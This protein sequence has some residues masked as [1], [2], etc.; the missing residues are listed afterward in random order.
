MERSWP[1]LRSSPSVV[2]RQKETKNFSQ[3]KRSAGWT[4]NWDHPNTK[5][6]HIRWINLKPRRLVILV[7]NLRV[8]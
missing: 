1:I 7:L 5:I 3:D 2:K 8:L 4:S 6:S